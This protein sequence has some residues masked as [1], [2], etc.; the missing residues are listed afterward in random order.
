MLDDDDELEGLTI[1]PT[2]IDATDVEPNGV[3]DEVEL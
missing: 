1:Q 3:D 2:A